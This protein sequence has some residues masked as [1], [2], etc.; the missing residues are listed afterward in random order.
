MP[1]LCEH[2]KHVHLLD[3][4]REGVAANSASCPS[5]S[6]PEYN[7]ER[8]GDHPVGLYTIELVVSRTAD[9]KLDLGCVDHNRILSLHCRV[10]DEALQRYLELDSREPLRAH[11][12]YLFDKRDGRDGAADQL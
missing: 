10:G 11:F 4:D 5:R 1:A 8:H 6:R 12:R 7:Y 9:G 2:S 3:D